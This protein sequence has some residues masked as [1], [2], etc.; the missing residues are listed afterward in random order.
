MKSQPL[1][2]TSTLMTET[3]TLEKILYYLRLGKSRWSNCPGIESSI[4]ERAEPHTS[5]SPLAP[6]HASSIDTPIIWPIS[7]SMISLLFHYHVLDWPS[8]RCTVRAVPVAV[9]SFGVQMVPEAETHRA[10]MDGVRDVVLIRV[11]VLLGVR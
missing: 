8:R 2:F 5:Y 10:G 6:I 7:R 11:T 1:V 4:Y 9:V 3:P